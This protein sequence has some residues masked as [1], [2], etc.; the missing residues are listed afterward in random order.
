LYDDDDDN[1]LN[2]A[3]A[4]RKQRRPLQLLDDDNDSGASGNKSKKLKSSDDGGVAEAS[5]DDG[6]DD[7]LDAFMAG[8]HETMKKETEAPKTKL[9][10]DDFEDEDDMETFLKHRKQQILQQQQQLQQQGQQP[11]SGNNDDDDDDLTLPEAIEYAPPLLLSLVLL[12]SQLFIQFDLIQSQLICGFSTTTF[13][14]DPQIRLRRQSD[15]KEEEHRAL[16]TV[17]PQ[18]HRLSYFRERLLRR[19]S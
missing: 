11:S 2:E 4:F 9:R 10:R 12:L 13:R 5:K 1:D 17:G 15:R 16:G 7:P 6:E 14:F 3:A 19:A 8:V 18:E